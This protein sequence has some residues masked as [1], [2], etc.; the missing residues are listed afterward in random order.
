MQDETCLSAF[1][2]FPFIIIACTLALLPMTE[3]SCIGKE[4]R[5]AILHSIEKR[6]FNRS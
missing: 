2:K 3:E 6:R 5:P 4:P 1:N